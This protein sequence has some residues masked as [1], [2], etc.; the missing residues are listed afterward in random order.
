[1]KQLAEY[2]P[3]ALFFIVFFAFGKDIYLA[4]AVLMITYSIGMLILW[5]LDGHLSKTHQIMWLAIVIFGGLTV[6]LRN[7]LFI[8]WKPTIANWIMAVVF[9]G[10]HH[11]AQKKPLIQSML[12]NSIKLEQHDWYSL[13]KLWI[14]FFILCGALNLYVA[15]NYPTDFWVKFKVIGLLGLT[16]VFSVIQGIWLM[17]KADFSEDENSIETQKNQTAL[18]RIEKIRMKLNSAFTDASIELEDESHLHIGH[19]GAQD[20]RGHFRLNIVS[21]AFSNKSRIQR[22]QMI[23]S[24]LDQ[25]M[26]TDIHALSIIAKTPDEV[27]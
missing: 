12:G 1:M 26:Q 22:H 9:L 25:M 15:Y 24:A 19:A 6:I 3:L 13:S 4:T 17:K 21:E 23:F 10:S 18:P 8:K 5:K 14:G 20:G 27:F 16:L 2:G 7:E 11:I